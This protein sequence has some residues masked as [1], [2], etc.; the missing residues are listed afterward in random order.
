MCHQIKII[1]KNT[2]GELSICE[3]CK[4]Y[5]LTFN[6]LYIEFDFEEMLSF[7]NFVIGIE[8]DY[9][10]TKYNCMSMK[11][12]IPIQT[13]QSNL[14]MIFNRQELA[15]LRDLLTQTTKKPYGNLS[16]VEIDYTLFLN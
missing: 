2:N 6:N 8:V 1:A 16:V 11:R 14:V 10:E 5:H 12:K 9:W 4:V 7:K 13:Q 3:N 15:S